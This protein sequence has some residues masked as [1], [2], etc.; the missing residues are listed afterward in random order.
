[1]YEFNS[2]VYGFAMYV[3]GVQQQ[4]VQRVGAS[5]HCTAPC[6]ASMAL[7]TLVVCLFLQVKWAGQRAAAARAR[8]AQSSLHLA[9]A[10]ASARRG[11]LPPCG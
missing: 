9:P 8:A 11:R 1:M 3:D 5:P 10:A 7:L 6:T 2:V 4:E